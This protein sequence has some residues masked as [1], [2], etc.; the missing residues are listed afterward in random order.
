MINNHA[1]PC[2]LHQ[3]CVCDKAKFPFRW[4][5]HSEVC[6]FLLSTQKKTW[7]NNEISLLF[8]FVCYIYSIKSLHLYICYIIILIFIVKFQQSHLLNLLHKNIL[9][10]SIIPQLH[11]LKKAIIH[12]LK[13]W[14]IWHS[15][16]W[17]KT[18][19]LYVISFGLRHIAKSIRQTYPSFEHPP[20]NCS[21]WANSIKMM[22]KK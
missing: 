20:K 16:Y 9:I 5:I 6:H 18:E 13:G 2:K 7:Y 14:N 10:K 11:Y 4:P 12:M 15:Y 19:N 21:L 22:P 3:I 17:K 1:L 8:P